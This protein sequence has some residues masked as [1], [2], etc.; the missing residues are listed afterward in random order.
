MANDEM[1]QLLNEI[2]QLLTEDREY[3]F[4]PTLLY[5]QLDHNMVGE[6]IFKELGNQVLYYWPVS[7]RLPYALLDL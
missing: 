5:T 2:G 4:E 3:P 7:R 1:E 6:S